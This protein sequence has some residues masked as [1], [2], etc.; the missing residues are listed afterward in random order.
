MSMPARWNSV[1]EVR[2]LAASTALAVRKL[3]PVS[4]A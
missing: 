3:A 4:W 1:T 2:V